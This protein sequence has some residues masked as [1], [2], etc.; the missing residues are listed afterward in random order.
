MLGNLEHWDTLLIS[1]ENSFKRIK[2]I[3]IIAGLV[4]H[5]P[6]SADVAIL[7]GPCARSRNGKEPKTIAY[8]TVF[9]REGITGLVHKAEARVGDKSQQTEER[10]RDQLHANMDN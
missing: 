1:R 10:I 5:L 4:N 6:V 2:I 3:E 8:T 7:W 9:R